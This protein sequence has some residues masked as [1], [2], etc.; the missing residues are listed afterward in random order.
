MSQLQLDNH[1]SLA[2][3]VLLPLSFQLL[4]IQIISLS[5]ILNMAHDTNIYAEV[6]TI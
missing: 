3:Q 1:L 6:I 2:S 4:W 5:V